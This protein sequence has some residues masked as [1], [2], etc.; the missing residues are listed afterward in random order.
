MNHSITRYL[1]MRDYLRRL[2][3]GEMVPKAYCEKLA[4]L[5]KTNL[6]NYGYDQC[7][8]NRS[9]KESVILVNS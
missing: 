7:Q 9:L 4:K 6:M 2:I 8:K 1:E 3:L 5:N